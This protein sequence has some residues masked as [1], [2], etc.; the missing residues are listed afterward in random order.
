MSTKLVLFAIAH[1]DFQPIEYATPKKLIEQSGYK[2]IT[3]SSELGMAT[4][5]DGSQVHVDIMLSKINMDHYDGIFFV[6]GSGALKDL[7]NQRSY[8]LIKTAHAIHKVVGAICIST[9]ILAKA[10]ILTERSATG[11]NGDNELGS[12][13]R[14]YH[15]NYVNENVVI[16]DTIITASGPTAAEQ[17]GQNCI[18]LLQAQGSWE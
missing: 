7:D 18:A 8:A 3:A 5:T 14:K 12:L 6:G 4:A 15:V 10:G 13:Y 17:Y 11:W 16:D 9:R 2:V 1:Q